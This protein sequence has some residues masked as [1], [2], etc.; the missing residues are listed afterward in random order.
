V[1][2]EINK[3]CELGFSKGGY[4]VVCKV[5]AMVTGMVEVLV[6]EA[7]ELGFSEGGYKVVSKVEAW[8]STWLQCWLQKLLSLVLVKVVNEAMVIDMV[9]ILV[10]KACELSFRLKPWLHGCRHGRRLPPSLALSS[11]LL[12][13]FL[14]WFFR[15]RMARLCQSRKC[16]Q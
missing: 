13:I 2:T 1:E 8:L 3:A 16:K 6:T 14:F 12:L 5:E 9:A 10:T 11:F 7:C 15:W 4:K